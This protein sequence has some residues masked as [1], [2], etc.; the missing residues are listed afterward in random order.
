M[1]AGLLLS[2]GMDSTALAFWKRPRVAF[3]INYGQM[4]ALGEI[5]AAKQICELLH[6]RHEVLTVDCQ[7]LGSGDLAGS[8]AVAI[9][10]VPEW[11]P[12]R[13]QLLL[14]LAAMR[15]V[16]IGVT[17]LMFGSVA[18]DSSHR[19]G[20]A[21]FFDKIDDLMVFQEGELRVLA[22][23][24]KLT[25][26]QLVSV[27]GMDVTELAWAHSCHVSNYACGHCRGCNKHRNVLAELG[28]EVY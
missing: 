23:A 18:S 20:V 25:S 5:R 24:L 19:D 27:S 10:P 15:A 3:T 26:A 1:T 16:S 11:W 13:N 14:T 21:E 7:A 8:A 17:E 28:Y 4:C 12:F 9:A 22:P 6:I 2:G